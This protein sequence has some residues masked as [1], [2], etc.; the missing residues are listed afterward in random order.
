M[1]RW[2]KRYKEEGSFASRKRPGRPPLIT[3]TQRRYMVNE[4]HINDAIPTKRF[5]ELF[6]A[7]VWTICRA[8]R[9]E[10]LRHE[11]LVKQ[12]YLSE[13]NKQ[14][15]LRFARKYLDFDWETTVF[16]KNY[17]SKWRKDRNKEVSNAVGRFTVKMWGWMSADG[18]GEL[19]LIPSASSSTYVQVLD[20][21]MLP[22]VRNVYP[23]EEIREIY[24]VQG[25]CRPIHQASMVRDW[26]KNHPEINI[27]KWPARSSDLNPMERL[28]GLMV[29][30]WEQVGAA[31]PEQLI[32]IWDSL[33]GSDVCSAIV[34][35]MRQ[36]LLD[37]I[38][39]N[40]SL[41]K[42]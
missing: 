4:Y 7:S 23:I 21:I 41:T 18:P 10:G 3:E 12:P 6:D 37:C 36:R 8:L 16:S 29:K 14:E 9:A 38:A 20:E 35:S 33:R 31:C 42:C 24:F 17:K 27:I 25:N 40:G 11:K 13:R 5:A 30:Q 39:S 22:T 26:F 19:Q 1:R 2:V 15:R 34:G 28:W 32:E